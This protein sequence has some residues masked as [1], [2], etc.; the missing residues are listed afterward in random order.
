MADSMTSP[1]RVDTLREEEKCP[2]QFGTDDCLLEEGHCS[3]CGYTSPVLD[4]PDLTKARKF[5]EQ[6]KQQEEQFK[7]NFDRN[8][9]KLERPG[10]PSFS[11]T[12]D[13]T[14][15]KQAY[16]VPGWNAVIYHPSLGMF[17][18]DN[19]AETHHE[20]TTR[21]LP[22]ELQDE[23]NS[24]IIY[25]E[26]YRAL[27]NPKTHELAHMS[28]PDDFGEMMRNQQITAPKADD[29]TNENWKY[30]WADVAKKY[31]F[32]FT[33]I[34][35]VHQ[36]KNGPQVK[37]NDKAPEP[38]YPYG[39]ENLSPAEMGYQRPDSYYGNDPT[40]PNNQIFEFL[41][42]R[43]S[44]NEE[45]RKRFAARLSNLNKGDKGMRQSRIRLTA[46]ASLPEADKLEAMGWN[47]AKKAT[48]DPN[49][50]S[51]RSLA[52][53]G[54]RASDEPT[55][56]RVVADQRA[57]VTTKRKKGERIIRREEI[58]ENDDDRNDDDDAQYRQ[59]GTQQPNGQGVTTAKKRRSTQRKKAEKGLPTIPTAEGG[60]VVEE[61]YKSLR[62]EDTEP[63]YT[64]GT[65]PIREYQPGTQSEQYSDIKKEDETP[66]F[67]ED[68]AP[69]KEHHPSGIVPEQYKGIQKQDVETIGDNTKDLGG[70][71]F[72]STSVSSS[73]K[74]LTAMKLAEL[75]QELGLDSQWADGDKFARIAALEGQSVDALNERYAT[76]QNVKEAGLSKPK[77]RKTAGRL[78]SI[79]AA[80]S[81]GN[82]SHDAPA[83]DFGDDI[84]FLR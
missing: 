52:E 78:P 24:F 12:K 45:V 59:E 28:G 81:N 11:K 40:D 16:W 70:E 62:K 48:P 22:P 41:R 69:I 56:T 2:F 75:E 6:Q 42:N 37:M 68:T 33:R 53:D 47:L 36:T 79:T 64:D 17:V 54:R 7:D 35:I 19:E 30:F 26:T 50:K 76:L 3:A 77:P 63:Q 46:H 43:R 61:Q 23:Q 10:R 71:K 9:S 32:D 84:V 49:D 72:P 51:E 60:G 38:V 5:D 66:Q 8:K 21:H 1:P 31:N 82:G 73:I 65:A 44:Y 29:N 20:L 57:P 18:A 74:V 58:I 4:D 80:L 83:A 15:K 27:Y 13:S 34:G 67:S 39:E 55:D 14:V 25:S